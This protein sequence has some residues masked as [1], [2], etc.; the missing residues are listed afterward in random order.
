MPKMTITIVTKLA[1]ANLR[2]DFT[3]ADCNSRWTNFDNLRKR[4]KTGLH[5]LFSS[6]FDNFPIIYLAEFVKCG[7]S[8][9][10][11][12]KYSRQHITLTNDKL[13]MLSL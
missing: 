6:Y 12:Q 3:G 1:A 10:V 8:L 2:C 5:P 13:T 11:T 9:K 4:T 7:Q